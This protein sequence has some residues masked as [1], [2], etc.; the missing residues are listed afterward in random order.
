MLI[1]RAKDNE[2]ASEEVIWL[3]EDTRKVGSFSEVRRIR[4]GSDVG[5]RI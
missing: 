2:S 4:F 5:A 3:A 1:F